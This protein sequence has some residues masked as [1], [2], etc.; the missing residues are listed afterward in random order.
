MGVVLGGSLS[1]SV[2]FVN[3]PLSGIIIVGIGLP[4]L[5]LERDL[6]ARYFD[7][8]QGIGWARWWP[9]TSPP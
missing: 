8:S 9:I 6:T 3:A 1:E 5:S 2:E 7:R 4:P